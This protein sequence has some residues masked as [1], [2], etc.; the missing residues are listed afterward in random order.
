MENIHKYIINNLDDLI[1]SKKIPN[2]L[3]HGSTGTG[4]KKIV[5]DFINKIYNYSKENIQNYVLYVNCA[6]SKGIKFIREEIKF[7][8]KIQINSSSGIFFKSI[9]LS[10]ADKLTIDAQSALRRCIE[11]FSHNTRFFLIIEDKSKLL[12][13][14]ISRFSDIYFSNISENF[15]IINFYKIN[16]NNNINNTNYLKNQIKTIDNN[17][18]IKLSEKLYSK[19]YTSLDINNY[20]IDNIKNYSFKYKL[21]LVIQ[22]V[23]KD[24][25]NEELLILFILNLLK[26]RSDDNLENI[27]SF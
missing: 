24:F 7:F 20:I 15:E 14:I 27:L 19:G 26:L 9:I 23:K 6:H 5:F 16:N 8:A 2:I 21:L 10:N 3:F 18:I 1:V 13:P 25:R 17:C 12:K 4:K 22:K 11:L